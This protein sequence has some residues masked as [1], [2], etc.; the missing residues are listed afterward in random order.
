MY[1]SRNDIKT[2]SSIAILTGDGGA[3][4]IVEVNQSASFPGLWHYEKRKAAP[5]LLSVTPPVSST[6]GNL[7]NAPIYFPL[8]VKYIN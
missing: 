2:S 3:A 4:K 5:A 1:F 6:C 7:S 8:S